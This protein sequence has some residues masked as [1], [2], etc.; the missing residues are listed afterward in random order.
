MGRRN[1]GAP[2]IKVVSVEIKR[3]GRLLGRLMR[4]ILEKSGLIIGRG[5]DDGRWL[6][7]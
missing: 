1:K 4:V 5:K 6:M 7:S 2:T 3:M